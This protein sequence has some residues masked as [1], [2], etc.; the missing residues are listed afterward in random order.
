MDAELLK[1][2]EGA[3]RYGD[4]ISLYIS[5]VDRDAAG[6][7]KSSARRKL[8]LSGHQSAVHSLPGDKGV[9]HAGCSDVVLCEALPH[10]PS[11]NDSHVNAAAG[12]AVRKDAND[13]VLGCNVQNLWFEVLPRLDYD[14]HQT[15]IRV[16]SEL[17]RW[18]NKLKADFEDKDTPPRIFSSQS[19]TQMKVS[20]L[21][22]SIMGT[23]KHDSETEELEAC[24]A[25]IKR[26]KAQEKSLQDQLTAENKRNDDKIQRNRC[27]V[28]ASGSFIQLRHVGSGRMLTF[29]GSAAGSVGLSV[30]LLS[31]GQPGSW[32]SIESSAASGFSSRTIPVTS[33]TGNQKPIRLRVAAGASNGNIQYLRADTSGQTVPGMSS[34]FPISIEFSTDGVMNM[35]AK[36]LSIPWYYNSS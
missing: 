29:L 4:L 34:A 7:S 36:K 28:I 1:L 22:S 24:K 32:F 33:A 10:V 17:K 6:L 13:I 25:N 27:D 9:G 14:V 11:G 5:E 18:E 26:L 20:A 3:L 8:Y 21:K 30:R 16:K 2:E 12:P 31:E 15:Q 35:S 23:P 19:S